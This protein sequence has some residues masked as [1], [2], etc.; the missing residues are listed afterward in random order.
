VF[1][2]NLV[3]V[4]QGI[5]YC[6]GIRVN[7][8][9]GI[10]TLGM[11]ISAAGGIAS[12]P[13]K[14]AELGCNTMQLFTRSPQRWSR[15]ALS[16]AEARQFRRALEQTGIKPVF[17]HMSYLIN[18][19]SPDKQLFNASLNAYLQDMR[20]SGLLGVDYIVTHM[21]SH[22]KTGEDAGLERLTKALKIILKK[23][24]D[25][26]IGILLENT[27][28]SGSSLGYDF[29]HQRRVIL[30]LEDNTRVGLCLDTAHM[31][32]AGYDI[33]LKSGLEET[34]K[35]IDEYL[36]IGKVK[37]IHLNDSK[38]RLGSHLDVHEHIGKGRIGL[39][40]M[41]RIVN[42]PA[43]RKLPFIL[44]TPKDSESA[45]AIYLKTVRGLAAG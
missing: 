23:T 12:V 21:G 27:S 40:A 24:A 32:A 5:F 31:F 33:S 42:H 9:I 41:K 22:K 15:K 30:G 6:Y 34:V 7:G 36:G 20:E 8:N 39:Q 29:S 18:L 13:L 2:I 45:D 38:V 26:P 1:K 16:T 10:M 17:V 35:E 19:A 43:L 28:G 25:C 4:P 44:E 14:A 11:H 3:S 37:L